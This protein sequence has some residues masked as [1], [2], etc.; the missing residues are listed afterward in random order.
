MKENRREDEVKRGRKGEKELTTPL[1]QDK[2]WS[3]S[4]CHRSQAASSPTLASARKPLYFTLGQKRRG[5][6]LLPE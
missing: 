5:Q 6:R 1:T 4:N 2:V 3:P